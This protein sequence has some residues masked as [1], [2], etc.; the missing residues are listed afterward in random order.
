MT[1]ARG[2]HVEWDDGDNGVSP[3]GGMFPG[4]TAYVIRS[5]RSITRVRWEDDQTWSDVSTAHLMFVP[6]GTCPLC[7]RE[8]FVA[9]GAGTGQRMEFTPHKDGNLAIVNGVG[10]SRDHPDAISQSASRA[11]AKVNDPRGK[12]IVHWRVCAGATKYAR[13]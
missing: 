10:V 4:R 3:F 5:D 13:R 2:D 1:L 12:V 9:R 6:S 7:N 8:V 11:I